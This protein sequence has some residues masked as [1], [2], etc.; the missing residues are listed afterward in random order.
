MAD[1]KKPIKQCRVKA[2]TC[3]KWHCLGKIFGFNLDDIGLM[4]IIS[5]IQDDEAGI[6]YTLIE[7]E[8]LDMYQEIEKEWLALHKVKMRTDEKYRIAFADLNGQRKATTKH[9]KAEVE[10]R[11]AYNN[12]IKGNKDNSNTDSEDD[13]KDL[14][15]NVITSDEVK[16]TAAP[17]FKTS[18]HFED[19]DKYIEV[20]CLESNKGNIPT[21]DDIEA[22]RKEYTDSEIIQMLEKGNKYKW[23]AHYDDVLAEMSFMNAE[24]PAEENKE[25]GEYPI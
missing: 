24:P 19:D 25:Q 5:Q 22:L 7:P 2:D 11:E 13:N 4:Y 3:F 21:I 15:E 16:E 6:R 14:K 10:R 1:K 20:S 12:R 23:V 18:F 17:L 8:I 9:Y